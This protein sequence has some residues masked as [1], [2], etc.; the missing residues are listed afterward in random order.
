MSLLPVFR[1]SLPGGLFKIHISRQWEGGTETKP[2]EKGFRDGNKHL[3]D[4]VSIGRHLETAVVNEGDTD[5]TVKG[6]DQV[7]PK[8]KKPGILKKKR[9]LDI[10]D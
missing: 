2:P 1:P 4:A 7:Q 3:L 10:L 5:L 9:R 8:V 6:L